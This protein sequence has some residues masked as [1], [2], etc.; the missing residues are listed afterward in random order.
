[1]YPVGP[2]ELVADDIGETKPVRPNKRG[3]IIT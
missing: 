1:M 3:A 2:P